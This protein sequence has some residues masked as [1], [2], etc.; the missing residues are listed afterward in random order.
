[1]NN[2]TRYINLYTENAFMCE[3]QIEYFRDRTLI[4]IVLRLRS[5]NHQKQEIRARTFSTHSLKNVVYCDLG[6]F[7]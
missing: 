2:H 4:C 6:Q 1:M 3:Y 5:Q 7:S